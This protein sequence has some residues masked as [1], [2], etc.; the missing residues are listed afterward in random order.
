MARRIVIGLVALAVLVAVGLGWLR[1]LVPAS[2][3][4][5]EPAAA[6]DPTSRRTPP[7]GEVVG[8]VGRYGAHVWRGIPY[9]AP[10]VGERR[11]RA[12]EPPARWEGT[13][14]ALAFSGLTVRSSRAP[15]AA[16]KASAGASAGA[17]TVST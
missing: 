9:A 14:E 7:A 5:P 16:S 13:R 3:A 12:P 17:R 15:S 1:S 11:W 10:P 8:T 2:P 6:A 4:P